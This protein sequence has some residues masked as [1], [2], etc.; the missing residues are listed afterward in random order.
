MGF[1][2]YEYNGE[3]AFGWVREDLI[4]PLDARSLADLDEVRT[5]LGACRAS[6]PVA[7]VLLL[8]PV[9]PTSK[10]IGV[11]MNYF[12]ALPLCVDAPAY[13]LLFPNMS[14]V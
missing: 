1:A 3:E 6:V 5:T 10:V 8:P 2:R 7:H 13:L 12:D 14:R 4:A 11:G 9:S